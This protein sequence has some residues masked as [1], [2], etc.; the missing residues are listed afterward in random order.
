M[1]GVFLRLIFVEK[2]HDLAH[3]RAHRI[4]AQVLGDRDDLHAVLRE[5]ADIA[6]KL[7]LIAEKARE[8]VNED[9][10]ECRRPDQCR[11]DH[12]LKGRAPIVRRAAARLD[13]VL[14]DRPAA[15]GAIALDLTALVGDRQVALG[16]PAGRDA[17]IGN[18]T[19]Y[20]WR[21]ERKFGTHGGIGR[22]LDVLFV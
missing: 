20:R 21:R 18:N 13:I 6:L 3:H 15:S 10:A 22:Q 17:K 12:L 5:L 2:G 4:V 7:E 16:L 11:I 14:H 8:A 19:G 1:L 9:R